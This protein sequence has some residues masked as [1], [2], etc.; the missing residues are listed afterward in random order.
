MPALAEAPPR[1]QPW[2]APRAKS[3]SNELGPDQ[4]AALRDAFDRLVESWSAKLAALAPQPAR[5]Q[6]VEV[7]ETDLPV[8]A[9]SYIGGVVCLASVPALESKA[10]LAFGA[11]FGR[12]FVH[13]IFARP[14]APPV[15]MESAAPTTI[16]L[17]LVAEAASQAFEALRESFVDVGD[18][19]STGPETSVFD[20]VAALAACEGRVFEGRVTI[21][22]GEA[23]ETVS[24]FLPAQP[25]RTL[26]QR[27]AKPAR[28]ERAEP[29]LIDQ[30]WSDQLAARLGAAPIELRAVLESFDR[31]LRDIAS[32]R[33]GDIVALQG[34]S[35]RI[36][37]EAAGRALFTGR[38][39]AAGG[40]HSIEI[41]E[42]IA[43]EAALAAGL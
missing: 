19:S 40:R 33:V 21:P 25:L 6:G 20:D 32:L 17:D 23:A 1:A 41:E 31:P 24:L 2:A 42:A 36:V 7:R 39:E 9:E 43:G 11:G 3:E 29:V 28:T 38:L 16:E 8:A 12:A 14:E 22:F 5:G 18:L 35:G 10:L 30:E 13:A 15:S 34:S 37:L 27:A 4:S 26:L